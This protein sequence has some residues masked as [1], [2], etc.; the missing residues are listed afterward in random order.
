MKRLCFL[1]VMLLGISHAVMAQRFTDQL[2]RG[3]V[4]VPTGSTD[5]STENLVTWR[6]LADEYYDVTYNLYK[7]GTLLKSNLKKTTYV[8]NQNGLPTSSYQVAAVM[9]GVEQERSA[10]MTAWQQYVYKYSVRCPTGYLDIA[11]SPVYDRDGNEVTEHYSPND[12]ELADLDGDGQLEIII[13]RLNTV[14]ATGYDSGLKDQKGNAR[15]I[16]YPKTSKEFVVFDAY[17][18]NWQTGAATLLWRIDCGPNMVSHMMTE[19]NIIAYDWDEDGKAEVVLRGADNMIVFGGDGKTQLYTIGNMSVN[20]RDTWYTTNEKGSSTGSMAYTHSGAEFLIYMNG[21]TG[22]LYQL[23]DF[24]L[25]RLE[26]GETNLKTAWGDDYGHRSSK[27]FMGAPF[28]DGR[29]ASL[30]LGRGI[31]TRHKMIAMDLD[32][33]AHTWSERWRWNCNDKN[34]KWYGQGNHNYVIADVDEDGRDEIVYGSM[35]IDD[36]GKGLSTTG[37][38]HGDAI[39]V[40]DFDPWR[41]GLEVFACNEDKPNMNYRNGTTCEIYY[42]TT[43][44]KDDGRALMANFSN[45][46]PGSLGRSVNT[47]IISSV[48]DTPV[49]GLGGDSFIA[50]GDLNFRIYWDGD[51]CSEILNSPG[52]AREAKIDKPGVGRLFTSSGCN[53]NNDSKNNPCFLGDIIGDWREEIV[54]RHGT[55]IR[56]YTSGMDTDY[57]L[58]C[59]WYD[60]QYRQAM[61][62]QMMAYNQPPHLS[63]FLGALEDMTVA[64]PTLTNRGRVELADGESIT[65]EHNG[66]H[67][68]MAVQGDMSVS[69]TEGASPAI[70]TVNAPAHIEGH[71]NNANITTTTYTHT[72][73][74]GA[75]TGDMRLVKQGLGILQLP[76]VK[77]TYTG[78]TNVWAG[79]LQLDGTLE[80]SPLWLNRFTN[81]ISDGGIFGG[82][83]TMDYGA[84]LLPGGKEHTGMLT[85]TTL[86]MNYGARLVLDITTDATDRIQVGKLVINSKDWENGP[87]YLKPIVE[88]VLHDGLLSDGIYQLGTVDTVTGDIGDLLLEGLDGMENCQLMLLDGKLCLVVGELPAG[89]ASMTTAPAVPVGYYTVDGRRNDRMKSGLNI[90]RYSD[91]TY[92]KLLHP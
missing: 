81:L 37:L 58:P 29:K 65:A 44:T 45:S 89:I 84:R 15:Y 12:A 49:D 50:W 59:L 17:D 22:E 69:V 26:S 42:R 67:L 52:T 75:L 83:I 70:L 31:Y 3:L 28:L 57:S 71:D 76:A 6:R 48:T 74:G 61:V 4:V 80:S 14:D 54:V 82:G 33:N 79:T 34:S 13:K 92:R 41:E 19:T 46:Y 86:T 51:L 27:Y 20:T 39:H 55:G 85:A 2:D 78:E 88:F 66:Q 68:L 16:I 73:T 87:H 43:G 7:N 32:R 40:S 64:P 1:F 72:L 35:V 77:H 90:V 25:K 63:Y 60:H 53:M 11:L 8:D 18:I 30:F 24:P 47:S 10:A 5:G 21:E 62:W 56:V 23:T 36:N 91:G 9:R 38:G